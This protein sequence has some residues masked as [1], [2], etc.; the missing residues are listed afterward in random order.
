MADYTLTAK[1]LA[2][3]QGFI[4]GFDKAQQA[5]AGVQRT[6]NNAGKKFNDI[7]K[8]MQGLGDKLTRSITLPAVGAATALG[9]IA[10]VKGWNRLVG[11]DTAKAKLKGLGH[12]AEG[13]TKI[14][15]SALDAVRGTA[16]GMDEAATTAANAVAA[17]VKEGKE[18][19]RYLSLTGDAAAIAGASMSDMGGII[20]KVQTS[21][22][23]YNGELQQ[24]SD[25][26]L[27]IYQWLA[28]E[29][30]VSADA[31]FEM[32]SKGQISSEM[33]LNAIEKNIGG[34]AKIM[35]QES[36]T[37]AVDNMWAS[38]GRI[39]AN[40]LDAGGK[41]GGFFSTIKPLIGDLTGRLGILEEKAAGIGVKFGNAFN[42]FIDKTKE[43][44]ARFDG[45]AAPIQDLIIKSGAIGAAVAVGIG[46]ALKITG[47]LTSGFGSIISA[48]SLLISPI[49][50]VVVAIAALGV[51]FGVAMVKSEDFRNTVLTIGKTIMTIGQ[52]VWS[53]FTDFQK[54]GE[55]HGVLDGI[56]PP[57]VANAIWSGLMSILHPIGNLIVGIK[58]L[59][60]VA[61]GTLSSL[62]DVDGA[63]EGAFGEKG[64][65]MILKIGTAIKNIGE[66]IFSFASG[67]VP[68][69][70]GA[71]AA[72]LPVILDTLSDIGP[73][74]ATVFQT[75]WS[76]VKT[77]FD[78]VSGLVSSI[79][80][81]FQ[82]AGGE[83]N[84][85]STLFLGFNPILK[86]IMM[87]LSEFGPE[88]AQGFSQIASM[89]LPILTLLG[90]TLGELAAAVIPMVMNVVSS[91]IPIIMN[92]G[93]TIMQIVMA[94]L[95]I[96]LDLFVQLV[97]VVMSLVTTV[98]GLV[99]QLMPLVSTII[100]ALVPVLMMLVD[101]ILNIVQAVAPALIAIIGAV[102]AIFQAIMPVVMMILTVV[103][104]VM[105]NII[106]A[107]MPIVA[108]VAG[109]ITSIIAIIAPIVTFIAGIIVAIFNV[110]TPITTFVSGV[111]STVFTIV[112]GVFRS[113]MQFISSAIQSVA[114]TIS[115]LSGVVSG[116]FNSIWSKVS[117]IMTRV[118][119]K[120][121]A[122]FTAITNSWTGLKTFVSSV[123]TGIG[124]NMQTLVNRV[125]GFVNGVIRG[126]N[127]AI[128]LINKI[129]GVNISKIPQL[130]RGTDDWLGG[131]AYMNEGGRGELAM[132][133][134]GTQVI[135]HDVS[136]RYAREAGQAN[137]QRS[138][139]TPEGDSQPKQPINIY[140]RNEGDLEYIRTHVNHANAV[141]QE[142][143]IIT[144][145]GN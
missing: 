59:A 53:F 120:I 92:L 20:N 67:I 22:K 41:G 89:A 103:I 93:M 99:S 43:L 16:F 47:M 81:G 117:S 7:G 12:D 4:K 19:T 62:S 75:V 102:I 90:Q 18:L 145:G 131:F 65:N 130:Q 49:G 36:F 50:L 48:A 72:M 69:V 109:I 24:L 96:L 118:S 23:A 5:L 55:L 91:L 29:A 144:N 27:P 115:Q 138:V 129:P 60:Q 10:L 28:K 112:S 128:S 136:M 25:R 40:F 121:Q 85:L 31:V 95:P 141:D 46:P 76:V 124:D 14:M 35:G 58:T 8:S 122:V 78:V 39:G 34:A 9:G 71:F 134:S 52:I 66:S 79:V 114:N 143:N 37:A 86:I 126:I 2:D 125:K 139:Y 142:V 61:T 73:R 45:L 26:G 105:A 107:I 101:V 87:V 77:V 1:L 137:A 104:N 57:D 106:A 44:K 135:P 123:F 80:E 42:N 54:L 113:I 116:V 140:I 82:S 70:Q 74:I 63:L 30:K 64:V 11:I 15:E 83:V 68:T 51:A 100:D 97:P 17:G 108:F 13:V 119:S 132:L 33:F 3:A 6:V 94:V 38:V 110:I 32:A 88:I 56:L 133:P 98:I 111:F 21:N 84:T 127:T